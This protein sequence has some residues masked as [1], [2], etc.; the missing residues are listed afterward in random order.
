VNSL[1]IPRAESSS[2]DDPE[3]PTLELHFRPASPWA[4]Q[5]LLWGVAIASG[6]VSA[7]FCLRLLVPLPWVTL[8]R[9]EGLHVLLG[10]VALAAGAALV[11][12]LRGKLRPRGVPPLRAYATHLVVPE[13]AAS[14]R[15]QRIDYA[16]ILSLNVAGREPKAMLFLGTA[17]RLLGYRLRSFVAPD[18]FEQ[19]RAEVRQRLHEQDGGRELLRQMDRREAMGQAAWAIRPVATVALLASVVLGFLITQFGGATGTPLGLVQYGANA[20]ALVAA[21][22]W[23]RL[24]SANFLHANALHLYMNGLGLWALGS[25]L[26]RLMGPWRL[27]SVYLVSA[28]GGSIASA[29]MARAAFSVGAST[30]IFG[31]LG[32]MAVVNWRFGSELPGGFRQPRRWWVFILGV[33]AALPLLV[34]QI[35]VAAHLGGFASGALVTLLLCRERESIQP[36][37]PTPLLQQAL[38]A[39]LCLVFAIALGQALMRGLAQHPEDVARVEEALADEQASDPAGLNAVAWHYATAHEATLEELELARSA[40]ERAAELSPDEIEISDTL[41]TVYHRLGESDRA[42]ELERRVLARDDKPFFYSQLA[43]FLEARL[44]RSGPLELGENARAAALE[45]QPLSTG[46]EELRLRV[47]GALPRGALVW[48]LAKRA[49]ELEGVLVMRLGASPDAAEYRFVARG[50]LEL[51]SRTDTVLELAL[52]DT[53][54]CGE[55]AAAMVDAEYVTMDPTALDLP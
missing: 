8:G 2:G 54:A 38:A 47:A 48:A 29:L 43:R 41:A 17:R 9:R 28:L 24:V 26:E 30:A 20:P 11:A 32:S 5:K 52:V 3:Q 25:L 21:G 19:L 55:C 46:G 42:I 27:T 36:Q 23:F 18:A 44:A 14:A 50:G 51:A 4:S 53:S 1:P 45:L 12:A 37:R 34:P 10:S 33:N 7:F 16:D 40:A 6:L 35:D 22:Q 13:S 15:T 49:G 31:L 39:A